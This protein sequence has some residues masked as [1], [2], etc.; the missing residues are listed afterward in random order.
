[1]YKTKIIINISDQKQAILNYA[2][3]IVIEW[4]N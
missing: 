2:P 1:M 3:I 4:S